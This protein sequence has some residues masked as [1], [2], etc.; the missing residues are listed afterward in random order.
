MAKKKKEPPMADWKTPAKGVGILLL[1]GLVGT[2]YL[3]QQERQGHLP[4]IP[5]IDRPLPPKP[6]G[7]TQQQPPRTSPSQEKQYSWSDYFKGW[8]KPL[9]ISFG[10]IKPFGYDVVPSGPNYTTFHFPTAPVGVPMDAGKPAI[11]GTPARVGAPSMP[12]VPS[13][14]G[15]PSRPGRPS[16]PGVRSPPGTPSNPGVPAVPGFGAPAGYGWDVGHGGIAGSG[17]DIGYGNYPG[18]GYDPGNGVY[19]G[20]DVVVGKPGNVQCPFHSGC[21]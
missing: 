16:D 2:A 8:E 11:V 10:P 9:R 12:G 17:R 4:I 3:D 20:T 5:H 6:Q 15:V 13:R 7:F 21:F 18:N 19:P 1:I 14:A